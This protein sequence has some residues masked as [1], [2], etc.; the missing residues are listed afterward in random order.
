MRNPITW[1]L[2]LLYPPKCMICRKIIDADNMPICEGCLDTLPEHEG[3]DPTVEFA[4]R[5][6]V[7]FYYE[8]G[9]RGSFHRY[10]FG[11]MRDYGEQFGKWMA[12]TIRDKL[13]D[14]FDMITWV[15]VSKKRRRSRGFDQ[16]ELLAR[17]IGRELGMQPICLLEKI[18]HTTP[19]ST[20]KG[21]SA[22]KANAAGAYTICAGADI[23]G[24]RILLIDDIL[25]T[26]ATLSECCRVL[27]TAGAASVVTAALATPRDDKER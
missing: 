2:D 17:V 13:S 3:A 16:S 10:K 24:K 12:I 15:P 19:Q 14:R 9:L 18:R 20:L 26:G 7:T 25:T 4:Q 11:T 21:L 6:V 5:S 22:R 8:D 23:G 1:L 27:R